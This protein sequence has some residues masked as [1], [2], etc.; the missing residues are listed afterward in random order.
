M[1]L[2]SDFHGE[3][4]LK[5]GS[6][7]AIRVHGGFLADY[8]SRAFLFWLDGRH[9]DELGDAP[10]YSQGLPQDLGDELKYSFD[11]GA[12]DLCWLW[13][14]DL[15]EFTQRNFHKAPDFYSWFEEHLYR[16]IEDLELRPEGKIRL[17]VSSG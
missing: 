10:P 3:I 14:D 4:L 9:Q 11:D 16:P 6:R 17:I 12:D 15:K 1:S 8:P 13:L 5:D 7:H 2:Q